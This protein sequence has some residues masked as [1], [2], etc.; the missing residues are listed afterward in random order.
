MRS[1]HDSLFS[2]FSKT[3]L[4]AAIA[5]VVAAP[6]LAQNTTAA[7]AGR[8]SSADGKPVSGA[9][10]SIVHRESGSTSNLVTDAEGRYAARSLRVGGPYKITYT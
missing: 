2:G 8:V 5:I 1:S 6:A 7:M 9:T 4:S 10:V 3:A